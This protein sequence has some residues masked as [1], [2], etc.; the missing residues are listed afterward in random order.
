MDIPALPPL[1]SPSASGINMLARARKRRQE[2]ETEPSDSMLRRIGSSTLGGISRLGNFLDLPGSMLRDVLSLKNPFDQLLSPTTDENRVTGRELNRNLGLAGNEDNYGNFWGGFG[3]EVLLDPLT[4]MTFGASALTK[5]GR[6]AKKAGILDQAIASRIG[7]KAQPKLFDSGFRGMMGLARRGTGDIIGKRTARINTKL[8]E[9]IEAAGAAGFSDAAERVATA[10]AN[11]GDNLADLLNMPLGKSIGFGLPFTSIKGGVNIPSLSRGMDLLSN[12]IAF[13]RPGAHLTALFD[14]TAK[15]ATAEE[16]IKAAR[17]Q[18]AEGANAVTKI[19]EE[20]ASTFRSVDDAM[21]A[22]TFDDQLAMTE[23]LEGLRTDLPATAAGAKESLDKLGGMMRQIKDM[24]ESL[25]VD[26][27][28]L[29]SLVSNYYPR[30]RQFID[31][32]EKTAVRNRRRLENNRGLNAFSTTHSGHMA[33]TLQHIDTATVNRMSIDPDFAGRLS[34]KEGRSKVNSDWLEEQ[35]YKKY[36][37]KMPSEAIRKHQIEVL[38]E[39]L[40][41]A[42]QA[43]AK[44]AIEGLRDARTPQEINDAIEAAVEDFP[45]LNTLDWAQ[46]ADE[47]DRALFRSITHRDI[48]S[49]EEGLPMF[50]VNPAEAAVRRLEHG[51]DAVASAS[52]IHRLL[53][54]HAKL[55]DRTTFNSP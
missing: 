19:R 7:T 25:G 28:E 21:G 49:V 53:A 23:Y 32:T 54:D 29:Q 38:S 26:T 44:A 48:R 22:S 17:L 13:S 30:M 18:H 41:G 12:S 45:T 51:A 55:I 33:R 10:A 16:G 42:H 8:S 39:H 40:A 43:K 34:T 52:A 20:L 5:S 36:R 2:P 46:K 37:D 3:T 15:G 6:I 50:V 35:F 27:Q 31:E 1:P 4:Y 11:S 14:K 9:A 24:E 47:A